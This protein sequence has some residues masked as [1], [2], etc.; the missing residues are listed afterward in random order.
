MKE[1]PE[2][3]NSKLGTLNPA[4]QLPSALADGSGH[5]QENGFSQILM[6]MRTNSL[7]N[8]WL[9]PIIMHIITRQLKQTAINNEQLR[10]KTIIAL[11]Y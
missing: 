6:I 3:L 2:T 8:V 9:K 5:Q 1:K 11:P 10:V 7:N 4:Y